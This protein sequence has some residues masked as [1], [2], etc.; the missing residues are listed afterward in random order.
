ME[1]ESV[2]DA[3]TAEV[4]ADVDADEDGGISRGIVKSDLPEIWWTLKDDWS[5]KWND[6]LFWFFG[7]ILARTW[8]SIDDLE[9]GANWL[10]FWRI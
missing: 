3:V 10:R 8:T 4:E 2:K 9:S 7:T 6:L 1:S 5:Q